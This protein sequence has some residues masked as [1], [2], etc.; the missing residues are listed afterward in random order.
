M[1]VVFFSMAEYEVGSAV[2]AENSGLLYA[3]KVIKV[4]KANGSP[5]VY[6]IY[7]L[8]S[9]KA[10]IAWPKEWAARSRPMTVA[11]AAVAPASVVNMN[12]QEGSGASISGYSAFVS[13][14]GVAVLALAAVS[15]RFKKKAPHA[16]DLI[17]RT[18]Y[19]YGTHELDDQ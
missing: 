17:A 7:K 8:D 16:T 5:T 14:A 11:A 6:V 4:D 3:A 10:R 9:S 19:Y 1:L 2:L 12:V 13:A 15:I 18:G